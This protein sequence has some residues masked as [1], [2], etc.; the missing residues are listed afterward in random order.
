M[1]RLSEEVSRVTFR[2]FPLIPSL[3]PSLCRETPAWDV[4][5]WVGSIAVECTWALEVLRAGMAVQRTD[6]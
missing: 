3:F 1:E 5:P 4:E 2:G 6:N